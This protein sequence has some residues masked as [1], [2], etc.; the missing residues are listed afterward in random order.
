MKRKVLT[1]SEMVKAVQ[2]LESGITF[3]V[4]NIIDD[5]DRVAVGQEIS[6]SMPAERVIRLLEKVIWLNGKPKN[7]RCDNGP[8]FISK[9]FQE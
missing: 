5:C 7:I 1:E 6:M 4:L 9:T 3:R 2:E 8:E